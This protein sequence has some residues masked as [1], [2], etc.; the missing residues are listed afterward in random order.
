M[1]LFG[2][3]TE[4]QIKELAKQ[5]KEI[6]DKIMS[7]ISDFAAKQKAHN[8]T[9]KTCLSEINGSIAGVAQDVTGLKAKI[10]ELLN[11]SGGLNAEDRA[12]LEEILAD[13]ADIV[14]SIDTTKATIKTLD[15]ATPPVPPAG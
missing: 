3:A 15:E 13:S 10:E 12:A 6:G 14:A 2:L 8:A 5:L 7:E 11:N 9:I 4:K 1:A